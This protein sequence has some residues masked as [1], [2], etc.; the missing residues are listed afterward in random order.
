MACDRVAQC[1]ADSMNFGAQAFAPH[2]DGLGAAFLSGSCLVLMRSS[3]GRIHLPSRLLD[4]AAAYPGKG[5]RNDL[6]RTSRCPAGTPHSIFPIAREDGRAAGRARF[7][8]DPPCLGRI[9]MA[10]KRFFRSMGEVLPLRSPCRAMVS[11]WSSSNVKESSLHPRW[12]AQQQP[13]RAHG[14]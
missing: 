2:A 6:S 10:K 11:A 1:I 14:S 7:H 12:G 3:T 5:V 9:D 4:R 13:S 8:L